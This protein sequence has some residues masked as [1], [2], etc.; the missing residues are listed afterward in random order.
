MPAGDVAGTCGLL[1]CSRSWQVAAALVTQRVMWEVQEAY[2][3]RTDRKILAQVRRAALRAAV[4]K[5][6]QTA[7][8]EFEVNESMRVALYEEKVA[9]QRAE[10][11]A[12]EYRRD[13]MRYRWL[14]RQQDVTWQTNEGQW[15]GGP[16]SHMDD[17]I[18]ASINGEKVKP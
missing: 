16:G 1:C 8:A 4:D 11:D 13:A 10:Q 17:A 6:V 14:T 7:K 12:A 15:T 3:E 18:D 9:R 2:S 5:I